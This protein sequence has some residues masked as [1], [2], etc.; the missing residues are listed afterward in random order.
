MTPRERKYQDK[1]ARCIDATLI[2]YIEK[3]LISKGVYSSFLSFTFCNDA[4]KRI[5]SEQLTPQNM[6]KELGRSG[7]KK[8]GPARASSLTP[9]RRSEIAQKAAQ[10]RWGKDKIYSWK[11]GKLSAAE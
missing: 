3:G 2:E 9:E 8:G 7:G 5:I 11:N 6:G 4:A 10:V 1:I